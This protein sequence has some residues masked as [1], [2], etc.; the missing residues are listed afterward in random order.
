LSRTSKSSASYGTSSI[1]IDDFG[2]YSCLPALKQRDDRG[3]CRE[4]LSENFLS[5]PT[6]FV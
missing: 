5:N 6:R 1:S 2:L 4:S 3:L